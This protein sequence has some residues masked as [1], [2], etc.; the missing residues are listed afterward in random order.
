MTRSR[1]SQSVGGRRRTKA[2][3]RR[4]TR[5]SYKKQRGGR[6]EGFNDRVPDGAL[7]VVRDADEDS[8]PFVVMTKE[9][10]MKN[11]TLGSNRM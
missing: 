8:S 1:K 7:V 2:S 9:D 11:Y 4:K 5:R 6:S 10:A 3:R